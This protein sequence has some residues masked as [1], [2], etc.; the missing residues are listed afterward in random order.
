M[1]LSTVYAVFSKLHVVLFSSRL[2]FDVIIH[3]A[4][5]EFIKL[6]GPMF[7]W[8]CLSV[9]GLG[10]FHYAHGLEEKRIIEKCNVLQRNAFIQCSS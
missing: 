2:L 5:Q 4:L 3:E 10:A 1:S 9:D 7:W 6:V 8:R